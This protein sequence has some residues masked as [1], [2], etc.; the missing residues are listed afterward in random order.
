MSSR[1]Q[2]AGRYTA[3]SPFQELVAMER[4][5]EELEHRMAAGDD[6][7]HDRYGV[8]QETFSAQGGMAGVPRTTT[9][10]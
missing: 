9:P 5:L 1:V 2:Y 7:V 10:R 4:E 6:S 8:L 3:M